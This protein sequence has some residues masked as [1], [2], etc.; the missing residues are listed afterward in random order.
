MVCHSIFI[1]VEK[2]KVDRVINNNVVSAYDTN[3]KEVVVMGK[4]VGF[5]TKKG[6]EID[7]DKVEKVF[8]L[9]SQT[10]VDKFKE[11]IANMP[12]EH[13]QVSSDIITYANKVLNKKLNQNI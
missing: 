5:Q 11:L 4:G 6:C 3:G 9:E 1:G 2:M 13:I 7:K 8:S 10:T 12:L